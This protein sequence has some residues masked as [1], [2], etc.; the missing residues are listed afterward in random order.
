[1]GSCLYM[2][3]IP[4]TELR[5]MSFFLQVFI[6]VCTLFFAEQ[7]P[8]WTFIFSPEKK[9]RQSYSKAHIHLFQR[10]RLKRSHSR[11]L[12]RGR[13]LNY[14]PFDK[15]LAPRMN[16]STT[17]DSSSENQIFTVNFC[18]RFNRTYQS[19]WSDTSYLNMALIELWL[20]IKTGK[21]KGFRRAEHV[22]WF[23]RM[24]TEVD[25]G[26]SLE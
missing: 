2:E 26:H 8:A 20:F 14:S 10:K 23:S 16:F 19:P 17:D 18:G 15:S 9:S 5:S 3:R 1:M 13:T 22:V 11:L 7:R 24:T 21:K 4:T 6:C 12:F 25:F